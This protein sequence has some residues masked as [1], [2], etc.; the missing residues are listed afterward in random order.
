MEHMKQWPCG[1]VVK[2]L[3]CQSSGAVFKVIGCFQARLSLSFFQGQSNE[4]QEFLENLWEDNLIFCCTDPNPNF[5]QIKIII[6]IL[7]TNIFLF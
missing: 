3:N 2:A 5:W 4:Y 6:L 1:L 7:H